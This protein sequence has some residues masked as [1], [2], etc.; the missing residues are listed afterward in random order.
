[1]SE[2]EEIRDQDGLVEGEACSVA[3]SLSTFLWNRTC[4]SYGQPLH[5]AADEGAVAHGDCWFQ[6]LAL[7]ARIA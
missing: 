6:Q 4:E 1:M 2:S 5:D 7:F 3:S